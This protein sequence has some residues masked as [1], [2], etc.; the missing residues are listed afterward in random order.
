MSVG[1]NTGS[2]AEVFSG[3]TV[4]LNN[5]LENL[6]MYKKLGGLLYKEDYREV[7]NRARQIFRGGDVEKV[8]G[9]KRGNVSSEVVDMMKMARITLPDKQGR[10]PRMIVYRALVETLRTNPKPGLA[11]RYKHINKDRNEILFAEALKI[12]GQTEQLQK[13]KSRYRRIPQ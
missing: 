11:M 1:G 10:D 2:K 4:T 3:A 13:L 7:L 9:D 8:K 12:L 5:K 6:Q